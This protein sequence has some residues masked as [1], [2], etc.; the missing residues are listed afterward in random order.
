MTQQC[1]A[2]CRDD[3]GIFSEPN[4]TPEDA[5]TIE[6]SDVPAGCDDGTVEGEACVQYGTVD[7][8]FGP[9][10]QPTFIL[11][12]NN[13][14]VFRVDV[15][16]GKRIRVS[17]TY[18]EPGA[19]GFSI[20]GEGPGCTTTA[21]CADNIGWFCDVEAANTS[22]QICRTSDDEETLF[23]ENVL[24]TS[25]TIEYPPLLNDGGAGSVVNHDSTYYI[26]INPAAAQVFGYRVEVA[27]ADANT[28][29]FPDSREIGQGDDERVTGTVIDLTAGNEFTFEG[30]VCGD[31][32]DWFQ[33][34]LAPNDGLNIDLISL[35]GDDV[36]LYLMSATEANH[37][38]VASTNENDS[39]NELPLN[40]LLGE[41]NFGGLWHLGVKSRD[42]SASYSLSVFHTPSELCQGADQ[43]DGWRDDASAPPAQIAPILDME[44]AYD[45]SEELNEGTQ[46]C[47]DDPTQPDRDN[48][49]FVA[50]AG[51]L[52]EAW[53]ETAGMGDTPGLLQ[54]QFADDDGVFL[55]VQR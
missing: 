42:G 21:N 49:C 7:A 52:I 37:L 36:D 44:D 29:C 9:S 16:P 12:D 2:G 15:G 54:V 28:A 50:N 32:E 35:G 55:A 45:V 48:F 23:V 47:S 40:Y 26:T 41:G 34:D 20:R 39:P 4:D 8:M 3:E 51:E 33:L 5:I 25:E 13:P 38:R 22:D 31:D 11:C 18:S 6:L 53:I 19:P 24:T 30:T 17:V 1:E 27:V 43:G 14:D 10:E 46:I